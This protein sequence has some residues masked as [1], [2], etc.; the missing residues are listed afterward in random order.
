MTTSTETELARPGLA[1][2]AA[3]ARRSPAAPHGPALHGG[4]RAIVALLATAATL[5]V[6]PRSPAASQTCP[7]APLI[8]TSSTS[9]PPGW[10]GGSWPTTTSPVSSWQRISPTPPPSALCRLWEGDRRHPGGQGRAQPKRGD[11]RDGRGRGLSAP[12]SP[13]RHTR[14]VPRLRVNGR[15]GREH[16]R[17]LGG[18]RRDPHDH[19]GDVVPRLVRGRGP[20]DGITDVVGRGDVAPL[21][22]AARSWSI[23]SVRTVLGLSTRPSV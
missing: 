20:Q 17:G 22:E 7:A 10:C 11:R 21:L 15:T 13:P 18:R 5:S 19:D 3:R 4:R 12:R 9:S 2:R 14:V 1:R 23:E 6:S 16:G 8:A